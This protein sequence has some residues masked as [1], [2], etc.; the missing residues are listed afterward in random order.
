MAGGG[1]GGGGGIEKERERERE[2]GPSGGLAAI[3]GSPAGASS[4]RVPLSDGLAERDKLDRTER[5]PPD[6]DGSLVARK[7]GK[8]GRAR[9]ESKVHYMRQQPG[10]G[11][12]LA[13]GTSV[14]MER[15][16]AQREERTG[17]KMR[18]PGSS[19]V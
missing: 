13:G 4:V 1:G 11:L 6:G 5:T 7:E 8:S 14:T 3:E 2:R 16:R 10:N 19:N 17:K 15:L 9:A 12:G 18:R